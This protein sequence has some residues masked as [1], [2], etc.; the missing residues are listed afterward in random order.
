MRRIQKRG[1]EK[2]KRRMR[3]GRGGKEGPGARAVLDM[4]VVLVV[5]VFWM[6]SLLGGRA[7]TSGGFGWLMDGWGDRV[8]RRSF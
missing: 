2:R 7:M 4:V 1:Q 8:E 6:S 5:C 3:K